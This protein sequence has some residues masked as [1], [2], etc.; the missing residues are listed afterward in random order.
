MKGLLGMRYLNF[1]GLFPARRRLST[2]LRRCAA[3][4]LALCTLAV[5]GAIGRA[6]EDWSPPRL[7]FNCDGGASSL[8]FL[9]PPIT[10]DQL[11]RPINELEGTGV[12][13]FLFCVTFGGDMQLYPTKV[14]EMYGHRESDRNVKAQWAR[15]AA[16]NLNS[17]L[18]A[19]HDPV[20]VLQRRA[21]ELKMQFW[22][23][24]RMNDVHE[25]HI[26]AYEFLISDFKNKNRHLLLGSEFPPEPDT[27]RQKFGYSYGWNYA[28]DETRRHIL[29][30]LE[31]M[32][33]NYTPDGL[34]M[35]FMRHIL[36]F[37]P[38]EEAKG[39]P[40]MTDFV[41]KVRAAVDRVSQ[42]KNRKIILAVR[43]PPSFAQCD[44]LGLDVRTWIQTE[45]VDFVIPM[46]EGYLDMQPKLDEFLVAARQKEVKVAGGIEQYT[47]KYGVGPKN[48][49]VTIAQ[50]YAA[51]SAFWQQGVQSI[52]LFNYDCHRRRGRVNAYHPEEIEFLTK[53]ADPKLIV[54]KDKHYYVTR[55]MYARLQE[56]GGQMQLP[57]KLVAGEAKDFTFVVGDDLDAAREA[58][59]LESIRLSITFDRSGVNWNSIGLL[60]NSTRL[61]SDTRSV[62]DKTLTFDDP[63]AKLGH[64]TLS[65][66]LADDSPASNSP[67]RVEK[68][69]LLI[70]Y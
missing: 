12:D 7:L 19:G 18:K 37:K 38:G 21:H 48:R 50:E 46:H 61:N 62:T 47:R 44:R 23:S 49:T 32:L 66:K 55:D 5:V 34:E 53:A 40:L 45:L 27:A 59:L 63:P 20:R 2:V 35:D 6:E 51:V 17:L 57:A 22:L 24:M 3:F 25:D 58:G 41:S 16:A 43:V 9:K 52:Y 4:C 31:E 26:E 14:S 54:R 42:K 68:I 30:V 11:C 64:N 70:D 33:D 1:V 39:M 36:Y 56:K 60:L 65:I 8:S 69:E 15:N 10:P 29:A 67:L 13:A 28:Q